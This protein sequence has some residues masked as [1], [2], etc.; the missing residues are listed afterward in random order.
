MLEKQGLY[1]ATK[2]N[3]KRCKCCHHITDF[4]YLHLKISLL[5]KTWIVIQK[6]SY[7]VF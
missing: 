3:H 5:I 1:Y 2:C 7:T 4:P 6:T